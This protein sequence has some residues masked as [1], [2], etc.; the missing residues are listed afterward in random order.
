LSVFATGDDNRAGFDTM[1]RQFSQLFITESD[2]RED[3]SEQIV[4]GDLL[5]GVVLFSKRVLNPAGDLAVLEFLSPIF[6]D[7]VDFILGCRGRDFDLKLPV[8]GLFGAGAEKVRKGFDHDLFFWM[9]FKTA[10]A[11]TA[12]LTFPHEQVNRLHALF[13]S[14][15]FGMT[16]ETILPGVFQAGVALV[17]LGVDDVIAGLVVDHRPAGVALVLPLNVE[18]EIGVLNLLTNGGPSHGCG[19]GVSDG[20]Q[21]GGAVAGLPQNPDGHITEAFIFLTSGLEF[22][23]GLQV[24]SDGIDQ[25][26]GVAAIPHCSDDLRETNV[27]AEAVTNRT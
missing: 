11:T 25:P 4:H 2:R 19:V 20:D 10:T 21:F 18:G 8:V 24:R 17:F 1:L 7:L 13:S 27:S 14:T 22:L 26:V 9:P 16:G 23:P 12:K 6:D 15:I 3:Y 5:K